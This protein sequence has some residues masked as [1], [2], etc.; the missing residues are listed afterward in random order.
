MKNNFTFVFVIG[1]AA[2]NSTVI[3]H[4]LWSQ[5]L[6][7]HQLV[8]DWLSRCQRTQ[9]LK[10]A[11]RHCVARTRFWRKVNRLLLIRFWARYPE[12]I[13]VFSTISFFNY[14]FGDVTLRAS[15]FCVLNYT[16]KS[17]IL[18]FIWIMQDGGSGSVT[19]AVWKDRKCSNGNVLLTRFRNY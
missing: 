17:Y 11:W 16:I 18:S 1:C 12:Y 3:R 4:F 6:T 19:R 2:T 8:A 15:Y 10:A 9:H 7:Q 13:N 14:I 5:L